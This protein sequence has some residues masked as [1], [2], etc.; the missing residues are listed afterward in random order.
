MRKENREE[1]SGNPTGGTKI[2]WNLVNV[3]EI[4]NMEICEASGKDGLTKLFLMVN[5]AL[6]RLSTVRS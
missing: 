6:D 3:I 5:G 4:I 1:G 2:H